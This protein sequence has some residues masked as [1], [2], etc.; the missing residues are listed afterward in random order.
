MCHVR[1]VIKVAYTFW[2]KLAADSGFPLKFVVHDGV[3]AK[4]IFSGVWWMQVV[5]THF[6]HNRKK[7]ASWNSLS[8]YYIQLLKCEEERI[9][10]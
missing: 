1:I 9:N 2:S 8:Q 3:T 4:Y 6:A 10:E 7:H 5:T